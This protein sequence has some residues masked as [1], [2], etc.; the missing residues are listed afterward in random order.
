[1]SDETE[2]EKEGGP[3]PFGHWHRQ[4]NS[5]I[6]P[7]KYDKDKGEIQIADA[8]WILMRSSTFREMVK[9]TEET[10]G[11][12]AAPIWWEMG[13]NAG[14]GFAKELLEAGTEPVEVPTLLEMFFTKGGW[15]V[16]QPKIDLTKNVAVIRIENCA[17]ARKS[18]SNKPI[19]H[20]VSGFISGVADAILN[21]VTDCSE[22]KCKAQGD[23]FC[24]FRVERPINREH[25]SI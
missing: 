3:I 12:A 22:T 20:F 24:E 2:N 15:G 13:K 8:D 9:G 11:S 1:V 19:C 4:L 18:K 10:L 6:V 25:L 14:K 17:T 7:L 23:A 16:V 5:V 21:E